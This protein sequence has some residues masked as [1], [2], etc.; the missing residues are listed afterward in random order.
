MKFYGN[1]A[2]K[3]RIYLSVKLPNK[4]GYNEWLVFACCRMM[5]RKDVARGLLS[6]RRAEKFVKNMKSSR[7]FTCFARGSLRWMAT[8]VHEIY[9]VDEN[10]NAKFF[11]RP[12]FVTA[13]LFDLMK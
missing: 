3:F 6:V 10:D 5:T 9:I 4:H 12:S 13:P 8:R 7:A 11:R 2:G 1:P